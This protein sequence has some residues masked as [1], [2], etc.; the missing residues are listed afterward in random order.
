MKGVSQQR[1]FVRVVFVI[2]LTLYQN[3]RTTLRDPTSILHS[4]DYFQTQLGAVSMTT[5]YM[6]R[7]LE[8]LH[9]NI[10][11][12]KQIANCSNKHKQFKSRLRSIKTW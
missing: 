4:N 10:K 5:D 1:K 2:S 3:N 6:R 12:L 8:L 9:T 7:L 11:L